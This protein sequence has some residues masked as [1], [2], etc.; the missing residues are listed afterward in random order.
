MKLALI[1]NWGHHV[2]VLQETDEMPEVMVV[3]IAPGFAGEDLTSLQ[4]KYNYATTYDNHHEMLAEAQPD[5]VMISTQLDLIPY[6]AIDAANAGCHT[7]CEKPL[8]TEHGALQKLWDAVVKNKTQ[9]IAMLPNRNQPILAAAK[10]VV[11]SG[12]I[13]EVKL[14]NARKSYKFGNERPEWLRRRSSYGGTIPWIGIHA[15]DFI[16]AILNTP[17][18][19]VS[20]Q[21]D[22]VAH[23]QHP[24][25]EDACTMNLK[26]AN[27]ALA[28]VSVDYLRPLSASCHGDDW[29]RIA[30]TEGIIEACMDRGECTVIDS[31]GHSEIIDF[32]DPEPYYAP[33]MRV[34][35]E[36]G[37]GSPTEET[38]RAFYLTHVGLCARDAADTNT[39]VNDLNGPWI[40]N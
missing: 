15:L 4:D 7:I 34:F 38:R 30:G 40:K 11:E 32:D 37:T 6:L 35:P 19:S 33:L 29:I 5:V 13:G 26:L 23:P 28:S 24:E 31:D 39:I 20:A 12:R 10:Q 8:A 36:A 1:G 27:G 21:H 25:I 3:G 18:N 16:N 17:F 2:N 9:C 14:L 22:N